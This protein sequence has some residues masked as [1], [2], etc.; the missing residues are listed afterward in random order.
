MIYVIEFLNK[1]NHSIVF[2]TILNV[3]TD[4]FIS[5][6]FKVTKI[7]MT[8]FIKQVGEFTKND[9]ILLP[10]V[11]TRNNPKLLRNNCKYICINTE[12]FY[13]NQK[14]RGIVDSI[15]KYADVV[16]DY[17]P[18]NIQKLNECGYQKAYMLP[19]CY[20]SYY[21]KLYSSVNN[22]NKTIDVL[23]YGTQNGR[24]IK[25]F[26][27][28]RY[29]HINLYTTT[30]F[31]NLKKQNEYISKSKLVIIPFSL[32]KYVE[33]DFYRAPYLITNKALVV[34]EYINDESN[35]REL[36]ENLTFAKYNEFVPVIKELLSKTQEERDDLALKHYEYFKTKWNI[37]D[38]DLPPVL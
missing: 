20:C 37:L 33:F 9:Y 34:H 29:S 25:L 26:K 8:Q 1:N 36:R 24:R 31:N 12:P 11:L 18:L 38:F 14:W 32:K 27:Q 30:C 35:I 28:L 15:L 4:F 21:E 19:P 16:L 6:G 22:T 13:C 2:N 17:C 10:F 5:K 7:S 23:F 3:Y